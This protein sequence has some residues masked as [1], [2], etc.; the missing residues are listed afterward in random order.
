MW[1]CLFFQAEDGIR[2]W[3][4]TGVQ[5][6]ALPIFGAVVR[7]S[8]HHIDGDTTICQAVGQ[9]GGGHP[10]SA[11]QWW[12]L[13]IQDQDAHLELLQGRESSGTCPVR[14]RRRATSYCVGNAKTCAAPGGQEASQRQIV[15]ADC[16]RICLD[17]PK[18]LGD[19]P[20]G[21]ALQCCLEETVMWL[22]SGRCSGPAT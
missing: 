16:C 14:L 13:V 6:C 18:L 17:S 21:G 1:S 22:C 15:S 12:I 10:G 20:F 3:S 19:E 8:S 5:T 7:G 2:D 9:R 11:A 4:V